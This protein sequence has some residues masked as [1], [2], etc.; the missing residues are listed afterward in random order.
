MRPLSEVI[1]DFLYSE[2]RLDARLAEQKLIASW[3]GIMGPIIAKHT[4][5]IYIYNKQLF[6]KVDSSV[7]RQELAYAKSQ[8]VKSL[9]DHVGKK[10][11]DQI[12]LQ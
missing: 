1:K 12:V 8:I 10:I 5:G 6:V 2:A 3:N 11:I 9:N 4:L 7:I